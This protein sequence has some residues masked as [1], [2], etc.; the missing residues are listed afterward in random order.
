MSTEEGYQREWTVPIEPGRTKIRFGL[1]TDRGVPV[2]FLVQLEY[3]VPGT[4]TGTDTLA[5]NW[6]PIARF[7]HDAFGPAYRNVER[8]GLHMDVFDPDGNQRAKKTDFPPRP[9][10][11]ALPAAERYLK[12]EYERLVRRFERWL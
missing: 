6:R 8:V 9:A 7:D 2:K 11:E 1:S 12:S 5:E 10:N 3:L 4:R